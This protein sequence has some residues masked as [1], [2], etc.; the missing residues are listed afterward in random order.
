MENKIRKEEQRFEKNFRDL[1]LGN[2]K[3]ASRPLIV[4]KTPNI[5]VICGAEKGLDFTISKS[6]IDKC[7]R[8]ENRDEKGRIVGKTGHGLSEKQVCDSLLSVKSPAMVLKGNRDNSLVVVTGLTDNKSRPIFVTVELNKRS[9]RT[10]IHN[11]TSVYGRD[12]FQEYLKLQN[13]LENILAID[14]K[15]AESLLR[16]IGKWYPK[17]GRIISF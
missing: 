10:E 13:N 14:N 11:V 16:P 4:G 15:K 1:L 6:V 3:L 2:K 9:G 17:R 8:P 12:R 7:L 5:L